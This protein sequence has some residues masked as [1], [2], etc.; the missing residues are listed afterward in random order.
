ME[1]I[2]PKYKTSAKQREASKKYRQ[3]NKDKL[4]TYHRESHKEKMN[5]PIYQQKRKDYAKTAYEKVKDLKYEVEFIIAF[6]D[7]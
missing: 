2:E 6:I 4:N 1:N 7:E 5:D 3:A